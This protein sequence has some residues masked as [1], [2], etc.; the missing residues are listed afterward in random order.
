VNVGK[1]KGR[2]EGA[3]AGPAGQVLGLTVVMAGS[4]E[5]PSTGD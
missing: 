5:R 1:E 2:K 3:L 4:S